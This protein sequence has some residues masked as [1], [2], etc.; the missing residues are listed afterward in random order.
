MAAEQSSTSDILLELTE[1]SSKRQQIQA[2]CERCRTR[3][4]KCDGQRPCRLC[5]EHNASCQWA[6]KPNETHRQ[7]AK[8]KLAVYKE[9]SSLYEKLF[10]HLQTA[11]AHQA[12][13]IFQSI[14]AGSDLATL[15]TQL[16]AGDLTKQLNLQ[17]EM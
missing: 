7:A 4:I 9:S 6:V 12:N 8:R 5:R 1:K 16:R 14:R 13:N 11:D 17:P 2:A 10:E 3:K 15:V